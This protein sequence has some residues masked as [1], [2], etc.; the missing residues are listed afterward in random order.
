ML[1]LWNRYFRLCKRLYFISYNVDSSKSLILKNLRWRIYD[2]KN[3]YLET[4][5]LKRKIAKPLP[6]IRGVQFQ[7]SDIQLWTKHFSSHCP[8]TRGLTTAGRSLNDFTPFANKYKCNGNWHD[9]RIKNKFLFCILY[10]QNVNELQTNLL[11]K[12]HLEYSLALQT[13]WAFEL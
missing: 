1:P 11:I 8:N 12:L 9:D 3:T 2:L 7:A 13:F 10:K 4:R 6:I 5:F